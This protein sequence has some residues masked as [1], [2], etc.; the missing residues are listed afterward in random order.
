MA[1]YADVESARS[2]AVSAKAQ[3][4]A[5]M[6]GAR[7]LT[8][9]ARA[10]GTVES[11]PVNPGDL[12]AAGSTVATL[13]RSGAGRAGFGIDPAAATRIRP[14]TRIRVGAAS[15]RPTLT[16]PVESIDL[17]ADPQ[18][19]LA[20]LYARIPAQAG[21]GAG[22]PLTAQVPL[23]ASTDAITVPYA[24]LLDDGG[25][26]Y[27][28]VVKGGVAHRHDVV[29]GPSNGQRIA[30]EKGVAPGEK[31]VTAGGTALEDG[32]KVRTK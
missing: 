19:R 29:T 17:T 22:Q 25:Q 24:A 7:D 5:M 15:G 6:L 8:L 26:P 2:A 3:Q 11:V 14:G 18:T 28:Y 9:R 27:V 21:L 30:I 12:V 23:A 20:S 31:V 1:K 16:V 4:D 10:A 13:V 32:M